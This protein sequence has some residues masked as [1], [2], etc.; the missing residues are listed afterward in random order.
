MFAPPYF[1]NSM[2]NQLIAICLCIIAFNSNK[3][4][5][6]EK[7]F[8]PSVSGL[9]SSEPFMFSVSSL[10]PEHTNWNLDYSGSYGERVSGPFGYDGVNQQ[11]AVKGYLGKKFTVYAFNAFG[12]TSSEKVVSAQQAEVI[13][14]FLGGTKNTGLRVGGGIGFRRDYS[15]VKSLLGRVTLSYNTSKWKT[16]GNLLFEKAMASNRDGLDF[17]TS[18]GVQYS[19]SQNF[20]GGIEAIGEDLE[21]FWDEE[22]AEGG[23]KLLIGPSLNLTPQKS[24]LSFSLAGG[25]V[26]YA[27]RNQVYNPDAMRELPSQA[28]L[29]IRA[30]VIFKLS[31]S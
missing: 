14:N 26:F 27:T 11:L 9:E 17:I 5:A 29:M 6:Q 23:A 19:L 1:I 21:G 8:M 12:F 13:R 25:P 24:K 20:Y 3:L 30:R 31:G 10:T 18:L 22:E 15:D 16:T 2:K 7:E 4:F 28:G